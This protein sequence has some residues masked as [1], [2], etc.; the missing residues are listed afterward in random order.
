MSLITPPEDV[1]RSLPST[2][3]RLRRVLHRARAGRAMEV[4]NGL[5]ALVVTQAGLFR[6][7][8]HDRFD[9]LWHSSLTDAA[10]R[11][12]PDNEYVDR[13]Q[14]LATIEDIVSVTELPLIIDV[15]TGGHPEHLAMFLQT[16]E[17]V[18]AAGLAVEDK[19]GLKVNSL[20]G[21]ASAHHQLPP[22]EMAAKLAY[23]KQRQKTQDFVVIARIESL[24]A[25]ESE[26][27]AFDRAAL[28]SDAGADA[29]LVHSRST[30]GTDA[31]AVARAFRARNT[32]TPLVCVPT[33]Y[34]HLSVDELEAS[35]FSM[36]IYANHML[37]AALP[38]MRACAEAVLREGRAAPLESELAPVQHLL[39]VGSTDRRPRL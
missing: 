13:T 7:G 38:A 11:G 1:D 4:H 30:A 17:R 31:L 25:G 26:Q 18:G 5:S 27:D 19:C 21:P 34:S 23:V 20:T 24:I 14:R 36:V 33:T 22:D 15:E 16:L 6:E 10:S 37:R 8:K 35:G 28:Y 3:T 9:A 39:D 32:D 2:S 12:R 29:I